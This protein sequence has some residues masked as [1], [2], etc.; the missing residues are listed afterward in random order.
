M[1]RS[2]KSFNLILAAILAWGLILVSGCDET[3]D[4]PPPPPKPKVVS[5]QIAL[6]QKKE[7]KAA[8]SHEAAEGPSHKKM[9]AAPDKAA[10]ES[11][12]ASGPAVTEDQ[13][14]RE[15]ADALNLKGQKS[16]SP[17]TT[18]AGSSNTGLPLFNTQEKYDFKGRVDPFIPLL[19]EKREGDVPGEGKKEAAAPKRTLT[20]LEKMELSQIKLVAV[21]QTSTGAMAMVEEASGKG[22]EVHVGTYMGRNG[23][24]V[25]AIN[26]DGLS[27]KENY[28]DF[29]GKRR[30][31]IKE[32]KFHRNEGG[33]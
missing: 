32:L 4:N 21:I 11:A 24:R 8:A 28:K 17:V 31:R 5:K 27:I 29:Q 14:K 12:K 26:P 33:E 3:R 16:G 25:S 10:A 1:G 9:P 19:N 2:G 15:K 6:P 30:E 20:P 23:G 22:Y 7:Q 18:D 13:A